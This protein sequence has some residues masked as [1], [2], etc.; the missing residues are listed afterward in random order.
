MT[1]F[2]DMSASTSTLAFG[3]N[4]INYKQGKIYIL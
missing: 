3:N 1:N 4:L 2:H